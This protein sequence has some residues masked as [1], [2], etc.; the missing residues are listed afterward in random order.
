MLNRAA[1][2]DRDGT[3]NV[4]AASGSYVV[5][6]EQIALLDGAAQAVALLTA[7]GYRCTWCPISVTWRS[8]T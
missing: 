2:L 5:A 6:P 8:V 3:L 7:A 1:F 4:S